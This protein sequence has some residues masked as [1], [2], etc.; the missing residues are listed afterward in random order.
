MDNVIDGLKV[1]RRLGD[2]R[3]SVSHHHVD[4]ELPALSSRQFPRAPSMSCPGMMADSGPVILKRGLGPLQAARVG[5]W[6]ERVQFTD[7]HSIQTISYCPTAEQVGSLCERGRAAVLGQM[8]I[9]KQSVLVKG[10]SG[11]TPSV[12][13]LSKSVF[14]ENGGLK[15]IDLRGGG[16]FA[17][18]RD[19]NK[20]PFESNSMGLIGV[21]R[22]FHDDVYGALRINLFQGRM[23]EFARRT[24]MGPMITRDENRVR[25]MLF[26]FLRFRD[27]NVVA[28]LADMVKHMNEK[29]GPQMSRDQRAV[30]DMFSYCAQ[31][32]VFSN[33]GLGVVS[34]CPSWAMDKDN[35][36]TDTPCFSVASPHFQTRFY[37]RDGTRLKLFLAGQVKSFAAVDAMFIG[38]Q[39]VI[40]D[41]T[42]A[43][44]I[45]GYDKAFINLDAL[46]M[47]MGEGSF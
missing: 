33:T 35:K 32:P 44:Q 8:Y 14:F 18:I 15:A 31:S 40:F 6:D 34:F 24:L 38:Y 43:M 21:L 23:S 39:N 7:A 22:T 47:R 41:L 26:D 9:M 45:A 19:H 4:C 27:R 29:G 25:E 46:K 17:F 42:K 3:S 13:V 2:R 16:P 28:L 10:E 20:F 37:V 1:A 12:K 30:R 36:A 11:P 5:P